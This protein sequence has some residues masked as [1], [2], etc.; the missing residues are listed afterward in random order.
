M[1]SR[2]E[3]AC[4][5]CTV[6]LALALSACKQEPPAPTPSPSPPVSSTPTTAPG[7]TLEKIEATPEAVKKAQEDLQT[8]ADRDRRM[9]AN[10]T[11]EEFKATVFR[12]PFEGGKYIVNG[13]TPIAS[14]KELREFFDKKVKTSQPMSL[15]LAQAGGID[16]KWNQEQKRKLTYCVST[17]F[18]SRQ[19][20]VIQQMASATG[21][22]EKVAGVDFIHDSSQDGNCGPSNTAVVFDVRPVNVN[23]EYLARAFFPNEPRAARN[24]LIDESSF[25]L[26]TNGKLQLAGILRHE[27]GH[28][29]GFR[30]EH[31]RPESGSCFEDRDWKPLT[32]YD[33]FSVMHYPQCNGKGDWSLILTAKDK[34]GA[35]CVY[36]PTPPFTLDPSLVDT[37]KCTADQ[38]APSSP[39]QPQTQSFNA[40]SVAKDGQIHYG[41]FPVAAGS[42]VEVR[43][44]GAAATGDPD[45]YVRFDFKPRLSLYDCRPFVD[46]PIEVC[47]LTVPATA[48]QVFVM[49]HGYAKGT[50]DLKITRVPPS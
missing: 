11:F 41:P 43:T 35:A 9:R 7:P 47:S 49:V 13:D 4:I 21:E 10:L 1:R 12:E 6:L 25:D 26:P 48:T 22:W 16:A 15:V 33:A 30:H 5:A 17:T 18:G 42:L 46:G 29:I 40:Q 20:G 45:L 27:L 39:G 8:A 19:S 31:T 23:E 50:Y 36:G 44:G 28:T 3:P 37:A 14:E 38:P 24:V 2:H 32:S 34:N